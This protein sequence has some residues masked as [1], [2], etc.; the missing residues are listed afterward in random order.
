MPWR[1]VTDPNELSGL[2]P[3]SS[4]PAIGAAT[5]APDSAEALVAGNRLAP[6]STR[7]LATPQGQ[8]FMKGVIANNPNYDATTFAARSKMRNDATSGA[9]GKNITSLNTAIGHLDNL[10]Q[11]TTALNNATFPPYNWAANHFLDLVDDPRPQKYRVDREAVANEL[12]SAFA[13]GKGGALADRQ[14]WESKFGEN[15]GP[16]R[17]KAAIS[18]AAKLLGSRVDALVNQYRVGASTQGLPPGL[19]PHAYETLRALQG[20]GAPGASAPLPQ[21]VISVKRVK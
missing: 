7:N 20:G 17:Q 10:N 14:S 5:A 1:E 8:A 9:M 4:V 2:A 12:S 19:S 13:G 15:A 18:E 11:S 3:G 21:G 16:S 6:P